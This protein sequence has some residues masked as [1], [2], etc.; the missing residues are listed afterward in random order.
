MRLIQKS[1][2]R[3]SDV[4]DHYNDLNMKLKAEVSMLRYHLKVHIMPS[5]IAMLNESI[6]NRDKT[7]QT[8]KYALHDALRLIPD[9]SITRSL[10][11][12]LHKIYADIG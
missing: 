11:Q 5:A 4:V 3:E 2:D 1:L 8:I 6:T 12:N 7:I 9:S 10:T